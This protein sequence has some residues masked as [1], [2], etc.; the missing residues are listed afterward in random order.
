MRRLTA[1]EVMTLPVPEP[2]PVL[3]PWLVLRERTM[4]YAATGI[5]KTFV[6]LAIAHAIA[7]GSRFLSW[8]PDKPRK[9]LYIDG[10]MS[11]ARIRQRIM[12]LDLGADYSL[13]PENFMIVSDDDQDIKNLADKRYHPEYSELAKGCDVI[14]IDNLLSCTR[15]LPTR[16]SDVDT[17][18][19]LKSWIDL[20]RKKNKAVLF[21]HHEGKGG[22]QLGTSMRDNDMDNKINLR[23]TRLTRPPNGIEIEWHF[24]KTRNTFGSAIENLH[25]ELL[26]NETPQGLA[27]TLTSSPLEPMVHQA[28]RKAYYSGVKSFSQLGAMFKTPQREVMELIKQPDITTKEDDEPAEI[29][30]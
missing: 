22:M 3:G 21:V 23:W 8:T 27:T 30:W 13:P 29:E 19:G 9:V 25:I 24:E 4:L 10:E 18:L 2:E 20:E 28:I 1:S 17:W 26:D 6:A 16:N 12:A 5:G 14:V 11:L 15:A 7:S